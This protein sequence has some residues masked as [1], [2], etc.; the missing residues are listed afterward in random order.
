[1]ADDFQVKQSSSGSG[2]YG[3]TGG[4]IGAAAGG[5]GAHYLTKAKYASH[6]DIINEAKDSADFKSKL[7][8]AEGEEKKFL[9]A[10]KEVA[11]EK[12][13]AEKA[14]DEELKA[15]QEANKEGIKKDEK[16]LGLEKKQAEYQAKITELEG[17]AETTV[18]KKVS[19]KDPVGLLRKAAKEAD[20]ARKE[21]Q[22]LKDEGAT[23]EVL[24]KLRA[25]LKKSDA[26][27][28]NILDRIVNEAA[29]GAKTEEEAAAA[30][31]ALKNDLSAHIQQYL[32][33]RD[34][35][36][37]PA[38]PTNLQNIY[39][40]A[41]KDIAEKQAVIDDALKSI[42]ELSTRDL[43]DALVN[44]RGSK[45]GV[46]FDK[47]MEAILR[48]E[49]KKSNALKYLLEHFPKEAKAEEGIYAKQ[50]LK[51]FIN[52][53]WNNTPMNLKKGSNYDPQKALQEFIDTL[54]PEERK[55][56]EGKDVTRESIEGLIKESEERTAKLNEAAKAIR[57]STS[58]I[59]DL[60]NTI[61]ET[62]EAIVKKYGEG[63]YI[64]KNGEIYRHG[65]KVKIEKPKA[66]QVQIPEFRTEVKAELPK[67]FTA[68]VEQ[69]TV[70]EN[71]ELAEV[72]K[73]LEE[74]SKEI[75]TARKDLPKG[76]LTA[77]EQLAE[78]AKSK[79]VK[80]KEEYLN[81]QV[82]SKADKFAQDFEAQFKRKYG[83]AEHA[84]WKIA[85]AA[86]L[87]AIVLGGIFN[88]MA[89]KNKA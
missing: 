13:N 28:N 19:T 60:E 33:V 9:Q 76:E 75:E 40:T 42:K 35:I 51:E 12:A 10:A 14:W 62:K 64:N 5:L 77:E 70:K 26:Q 53:L 84:N 30:K 74:V 18:T 89:P 69:R 32:E 78:F 86:A 8:K 16:F 43:T 41:K 67:G 88:A 4:V 11:D 58:S 44:N 39:Q 22:R 7:E 72:R 15:F 83:F 48:V 23:E 1:M 50:V 54:R 73:Q 80:N 27:Y 57:T 66:Q 47:E 2:A 85:G 24:S 81:N 34:K 65:Q 52:S 59:A 56:L 21:L 3:L 37:K 36:E 25:R 55:L 29:Y 6:M 31:K 71:P 79:G 61:N 63:A 17:K 82:K 45:N 87:G 20:S 38:K 49:N 46:A 68:E